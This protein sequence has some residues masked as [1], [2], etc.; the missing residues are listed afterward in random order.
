MQLA[1]R[2]RWSDPA[3]ELGIRSCELHRTVMGVIGGDDADQRSCRCEHRSSS[4][5]TRDAV[6]QRR[7]I[8]MVTTQHGWGVTISRNTTIPVYSAETAIN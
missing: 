2:S 6:R 7:F 5:R 1:R 8:V 4:S 3:E